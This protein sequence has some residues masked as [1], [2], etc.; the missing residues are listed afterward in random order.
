MDDWLVLVAKTALWL[1]EDMSLAKANRLGVTRRRVSKEAKSRIVAKS[2]QPGACL[3]TVAHRNRVTLESVHR[4]VRLAGG[5]RAGDVRRAVHRDAQ[6]RVRVHEWR[7][8]GLAHRLAT[9]VRRHRRPRLRRQPRRHPKGARQR[10][11]TAQPRGDAQGCRPRVAYAAGLTVYPNDAG[12]C[13]V[14]T[15][16][17]FAPG[18]R[19]RRKRE[20]GP[21]VTVPLHRGIVEWR[22]DAGWRNRGNS[23]RRSG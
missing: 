19:W 11:H 20:H 7:R 4:W 21:W 18:K 23:Y 15:D 13:I 17:D 3:R 6:C 16:P 14:S 22:G 9:H 5:L 12:A 8:A 2:H 10:G 1:E